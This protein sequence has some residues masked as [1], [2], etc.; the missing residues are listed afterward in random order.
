MKKHLIKYIFIIHIITL[1]TI[2]VCQVDDNAWI[3]SFGGI[4]SDMAKSVCSDG[5]G[6]IY[7]TGYFQGEAS[8]DKIE[9]QTNGDTDIFI[10]KLDSYGNLDWVKTFGGDVRRNLIATELGISICYYENSILV[11]G[12]FSGKVEFGDTTV[13]SKGGNDIF[14]LNLDDKGKVKNVVT[15]GS[16]SHDH[17]FEM[18][19]TK[20][21]Q[22]ILTGI[23]GSTPEYDNYKRNNNMSYCFLASIE[24]DGELYFLDN[25]VCTG[26]ITNSC[27]SSDCEGNIFQT[28][29]FSNT[30]EVDEIQYNSL[31]KTDSFVQKF[32]ASN[33]KIWNKHISG[34]NS[35]YINSIDVKGEKLLLAGTFLGDVIF[36]NDTLR[37]IGKSDCFLMSLDSDGDFSRSIS[38][39]GLGNDVAKSVIA[40][41]KYGIAFSSVIGENALIE[42]DTIRSEGYNDIVSIFLDNDF[43]ILGVYQANFPVC[44]QVQ[45]TII[46]LDNLLIAGNYRYNL[47]NESRDV[48]SEGSDDIL[49]SSI[50]VDNILTY[51]DNKSFLYQS[52]I[53]ILPN[54]SSGL[55]KITSSDNKIL[56]STIRVVSIN[57]IELKTISNFKIPG[58]ID[59]L[60]YSNGIYFFDI[61]YGNKTEIRKV[62]V[63]H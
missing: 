53:V 13:I 25:L 12:I 54:P 35:I 58:E 1:S 33:N 57:G 4:N 11:S 41:N 2:S 18:C 63:K 39:G 14:V 56:N 34:K 27:I 48:F 15:L 23:F 43:T 60:H 49:I 62:I 52:N 47:P 19:T 10:A 20:D 26:A 32:S 9:E 36:G 51:D 38:F 7:V 28:I 30:L 16:R 61:S 29:S 17:I 22:I 3:K 37:S 31:G 59:I 46:S 45:S 40:D 55:F 21:N 42:H 50:P 44:G 5:Y 24:M 8:F 6:N